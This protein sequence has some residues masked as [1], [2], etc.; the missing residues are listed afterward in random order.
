MR[1]FLVLLLGGLGSLAAISRAVWQFSAAVLVALALGPAATLAAQAPLET[2]R[3]TVRTAAGAPLPGADVVIGGRL[4]VS[5]AA[6]RFVVDSLRAGRYPVTVR[7]VGFAPLRTQVTI[8]ERHATELEFRLEVGAVMLPTVV[9]EA[10]GPGISGV[11]ADTARRPILGARVEILGPRGRELAT[12]S[13]GRFA[14]T[15][16][17]RGQYFVRVSHPGYGDR[18]VGVELEDRRGRELSVLL[19]PSERRVAVGT[20]AALKDLGSRLT[21][22]LRRERAAG[23]ELARAGPT[24]LCDIARIRSEVGDNAV[25]IVNGTDIIR[26]DGM[27]T[28][29]LLCAWNADEVELVEFGKDICAEATNTI[30]ALLN[31][32]CSGRSRAVPRSVRG[33]GARVATQRP[34]SAYV[35]VWERR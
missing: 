27:P 4:G 22:G 35:V 16:L 8:R 26:A 32:W 12:D 25:L 6:G 14:F 7:R 30:A 15:G 29:S 3:G 23:A 13:A 34:S 24:A 17:E 31:V 9:V 20:E 10:E 28:R 2:V 18:R 1:A 11:V 5:D 21:N 33:G 19:T